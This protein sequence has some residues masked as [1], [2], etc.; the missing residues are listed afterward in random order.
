MR[1]HYQPML[2][3]HLSFFLGFVVRFPMSLISNQPFQDLVLL[4]IDLYSLKR[5]EFRLS[6]LYKAKVKTSSIGFTWRIN[7]T[8]FTDLHWSVWH[9]ANHFQAI[10]KTKCLNN[11]N[12]DY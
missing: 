12:R 8:S 6:I 11:K 5:K 10:H 9:R 4:R 2:Q 3:S 7:R 1:V